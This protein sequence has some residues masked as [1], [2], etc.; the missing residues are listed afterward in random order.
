MLGIKRTCPD[1]RG[2]ANVGGIG[3]DCNVCTTKDGGAYDCPTGTFAPA[4]KLHDSVFSPVKSTCYV[5]QK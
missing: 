1:C 4:N 5:T 2:W 3:K